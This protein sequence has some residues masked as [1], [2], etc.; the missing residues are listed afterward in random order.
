MTIEQPKVRFSQS[1]KK[2]RAEYRPEVVAF[3][4]EWAKG[5]ALDT[6]Y[7]DKSVFKVTGSQDQIARLRALL[8]EKFNW[9]PLGPSG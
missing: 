9:E 3:A 1:L 7:E 6:V 8:K 5:Q 2:Y 4:K